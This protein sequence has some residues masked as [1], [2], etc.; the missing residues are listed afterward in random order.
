MT[1]VKCLAARL[2]AITFRFTKQ[3]TY[4]VIFFS[5]RSMIVLILLHDTNVGLSMVTVINLI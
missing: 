4:K 2:S 5:C 3:L 1:H